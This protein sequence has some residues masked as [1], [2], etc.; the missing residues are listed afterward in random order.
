MAGVALVFPYF[1]T[2]SDSEILLPPLGAAALSGQLARQGVET[3]IVDCTFQ[4]FDQVRRTLNSHQPD[5]VGI[6]SMIGLKSAAARI[7]EMV[8]AD[9]PRSLLVAGGPMPTLYP[10]RYDRWVDA[11]FRGEADLSFSRFCRDYLQAGLSRDRLDELPLDSYEG[12]FASGPG[13][14]VDNPGVHYPEE[15]M[16]AFPRM[17]REG[18]DHESY[19][20][21]WL[22]KAG[23]KT[24]SI[25][26]TLGCPF[27]CDF[28]SKPV[29]GS[30]FRRRNLDT[31][32]E[33]IDRIRSLGYEDLWIADD[34]LT[35]SRPFLDEFCSRISGMKMGWSCLA[36]AGGVD[37]D[38]TQRMREAGC[39]KVYLGL[40]SGSPE[41]LK[42]MNKRVT[43]EEGGEAVRLYHKAGI[44]VGAFLLVGYPGETVDSIEQTFRL[45]LALPLDEI[46]FNVPFPLPGSR[47]FDRIGGVDNE[48]DWKSEN[49]ITFVYR[50]E[51]DEGW[52]RQR[53]GE[54]MLAFAKKQR[55]RIQSSRK[56]VSFTGAEA[57]RGIL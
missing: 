46:S 45:A 32:F 40:E 48:A 15:I 21:E 47:L 23:T 54:T 10:E 14:R 4:A 27:D 55:S 57:S 17:D 38:M 8:R 33:E 37:E 39:R 29:F 51:H 56:L 2:R 52:L 19:Q 12:L 34:S 36:R 44:R 5:I 41:T 18:F 25:I 28:C 22:V 26:T 20:K 24:T 16:A 53:I 49:E 43:V 3:R 31:V 35:L 7:A 9:I 6:Y 13:L 30:R 42:L 50:T 1:R 11:V